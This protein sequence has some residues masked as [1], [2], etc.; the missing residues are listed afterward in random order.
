MV[1]NYH[2]ID[3]MTDV[4]ISLSDQSEYPAQIILRDQRNDLAVLKVKRDE[5]VPDP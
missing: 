3:Q 4:K 1:T 2:V 5:P